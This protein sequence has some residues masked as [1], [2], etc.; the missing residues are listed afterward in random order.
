VDGEEVGGVEAV[1]EFLDE[2][3][4][5]LLGALLANVGVEGDDIHPEV[6]EALGDL[7]ADAAEAD[8]AQGLV[9]DLGAEVVALGPLA[10]FQAVMGL[11]D[12]AGGG[13]GHRDGVLRRRRGRCPPARWRR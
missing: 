2:F 4:V 9:V 1:V 5:E 10:L 8:D 11:R 13:K 3:G 12:R 6:A 7:L